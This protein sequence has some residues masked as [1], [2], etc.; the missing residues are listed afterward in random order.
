MHHLPLRILAI[1]GKTDLGPDMQTALLADVAALQP[2]RW[3]P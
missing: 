1:A 2:L 3:R